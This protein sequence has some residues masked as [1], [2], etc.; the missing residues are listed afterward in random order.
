[1]FSQ[2]NI[3]PRWIIFSLD[4]TICFVS[5]TIAYLIKHNFDLSNLDYVEFSR[6][7]LVTTMISTLVFVNV[8]T[9]SGIIRYTSAQDTFRILYAI[10]VSNST[11]FLLNMG[12]VA[13]GNSQLIS[14]GILII[15]GLASFLMLITYRVL[16]KYFFIYIK[17]LKLDTVRVMIYGAGEAGVATKRTFDH[18]PNVNK[19]IIGFVD[20]DQRK[21]GKTIDGIRIFDA[22][23]LVDYITKHE[24]DEIIFASYTIPK[25]RKNEIAEVCLENGIK[26]LNIPPPNVWT[27]GKLQTTQIKKLNIE[28]LLDRKSIHIDIEGIGNQLQDKRILITGA[29]G[30]IG[31]EIVRQLAKF[32]VGLIILCD[33]SE[34]A[35]HELYL[36]LTEST[37]NKNFHAF[38]GDVRDERRMDHLFRTLRPHYVYHAGA[39]KHVPLMEDNPSE[40]IKTNVLGTKTIADKSVKYGVQKFVMI[41]TDKAVNPTNV[42]GASKR[43]AEIY[44][45]SLNNSLHHRDH[46]FSNGLSYIN[47]LEVKPITKFIT[48]RFGNVL[49]SNGSVIPRFKQQIEKGGPVTV[50]HPEIT[51]YFMTIPEACR[52]VL[53]AG[54]MGEGGEIYV[55]D[56][57]KSVKIVDL[58]KKMIQLAGMIPNQDIMIEYSGLRPGE[59]LFEELLNDNENTMPT[60]HEKIMIGRVREY[61]FDEIQK[62]IYAL[63][64]HARRSDDMQVVTHMKELVKEYKSKNSIFEELD[65]KI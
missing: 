5:L 51:R 38:I 28:D 58:A 46:I 40:A 36:E 42:M 31:S 34:S 45:Q 13:T 1:M 18:D 32:D 8:R 14:N 25:E 19:N 17:N 30:S 61:A 35:L 7:V 39:Y 3:V 55:F 23:N 56:M 41:S 48:T 44:V 33:Q 37:K 22:K 4:L 52:L 64:E 50:T 12:F 59:K 43:I 60:H 62:Q 11:F 21:M 47:D 57:G 27:D 53:E 29:A 16:V 26:I 54:C 20:D 2:I 6:N 24:L 10:I 15:N 49:G 9:Y 63:I 65:A